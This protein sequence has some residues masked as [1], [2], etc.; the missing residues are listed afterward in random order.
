M[1]RRATSGALRR[2][3]PSCKV[4]R[5]AHRRPGHHRCG[6]PCAGLPEPGTASLC[7]SAQAC[8]QPQPTAP[9]CTG[10]PPSGEHVLRQRS[11]ADA[12]TLPDS[13]CWPARLWRGPPQARPSS[14]VAAARLAGAQ[15]AA[16]DGLGGL[17]ATTGRARR[18]PVLGPRRAPGSVRAHK[19]PGRHLAGRRPT[20][21]TVARRAARTGERRP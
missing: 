10:G 19:H 20:L 17:H 16:V 21:A 7:C 3:Q 14:G 5:S 8:S 1:A 9:G 13:A 4:H 6:L 18:G 15:P 11:G 12:C 2:P